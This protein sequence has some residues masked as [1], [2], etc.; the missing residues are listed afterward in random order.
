MTPSSLFRALNV[1][2]RSWLVMM[3]MEGERLGSGLI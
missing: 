3:M 1:E 2:G